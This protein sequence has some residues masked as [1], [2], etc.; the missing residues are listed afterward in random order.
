ML[1][2]L[3]QGTKHEWVANRLFS[4]AFWHLKLPKLKMKPCAGPGVR[5]WAE[6]TRRWMRT[7]TRSASGRAW[8]ARRG[9]PVAPAWPRARHGA[10]PTRH[11]LA[12]RSAGQAHA[13]RHTLTSDSSLTSLQPDGAMGS[14]YQ[15]V[16]AWRVLLCSLVNYGCVAGAGIRAGG[17]GALQEDLGGGEGQGGCLARGCPQGATHS[18]AFNTLRVMLFLAYIVCDS[19]H[20]HFEHQTPSDAADTALRRAMWVPGL[21]VTK[22]AGTPL[23]QR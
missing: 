10:A 3:A 20:T 5:E 13:C 21:R 22:R 16:P 17:R 18:L 1:A 14:L 15:D 2:R 12:D 8:N 23:S 7:H 11:L 9:T 4:I 6:Q 19:N